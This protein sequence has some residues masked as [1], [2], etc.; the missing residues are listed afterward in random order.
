[1]TKAGPVT[2]PLS[3]KRILITR[4]EAQAESTKQDIQHRGGIPLLMPMIRIDKR[5]PS[6]S[7]QQAS[8]PLS[9]F[10]WLVFTSVNGVEGFLSNFRDSWQHLT[11][12]QKPQ[13]AVVG[14]K[15]A[16]KAEEEGLSVNFQPEKANGKSLGQ[17][18]PLQSDLP[19]LFP[20]GDQARKALPQALEERG[21]AVYKLVVYQNS[22]VTYTKES[23]ANTLSSRLD[24]VLFTSPSTVNAFF[25]HCHKYAIWPE[26][27]TVIACIGDTSGN[28]VKQWG[29]QP[30][31]V[32][33]QARTD[34]LLDAL[35]HYLSS[36]KL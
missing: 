17:Q 13:I 15:T 2:A 28:Q 34:S 30:H 33:E 1:M 4:P 36:L 6:P 19:I 16:Q 12:D 21:V 5:S 32:P 29:L 27:S 26:P 11:A 22:P 24:A 3:D 14:N 9:Q 35:G 8:Q 7:E 20:C 23:F 31:L 10:Q 18:L 25:D